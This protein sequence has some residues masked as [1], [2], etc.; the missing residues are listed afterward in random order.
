MNFGL[1]EA[2][3][4]SHVDI[5]RHLFPSS[6]SRRMRKVD[7]EGQSVIWSVIRSPVDH[8]ADHVLPSCKMISATWLA[9]GCATA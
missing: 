1:I 2:S 4:R 7:E 3:S 5:S 6:F 9:R 8:P